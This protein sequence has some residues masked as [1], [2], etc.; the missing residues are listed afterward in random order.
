[1]ILKFN[2]IENSVD[3]LMNSFDIYFEADE[4]GEYGNFSTVENKRK[5]KVAFVLLC[6]AVELLLKCGLQN[7]NEALVYEN[8][9]VNIITSDNKTIDAAKSLNRLKNLNSLQLENEEIEFIQNC[10]RMRNKH[11]HY[12]TEIDC[13]KIKGQYAKLSVLYRKLYISY[14]KTSD[15]HFNSNKNDFYSKIISDLMNFDENLDIFRGQEYEK[16]YIP[17]LKKD[18]DFNQKH[19]IIEDKNG[20]KYKR[21]KYSSYKNSLDKDVEYCPDCSA[22]DGEYHLFGCDWETCPE[23]GKQLLSCDCEMM[24]VVGDELWGN[25]EYYEK[26]GFYND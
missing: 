5:W 18:I 22:K 7:I 16:E 2:L 3:Y 25:L 10:F 26:S 1:M 4:D 6:Q 9:D 11:I 23:C 19:I 20:N 24:L 12:Q 14:S 17:N 13:E 15:I 8:I 21:I